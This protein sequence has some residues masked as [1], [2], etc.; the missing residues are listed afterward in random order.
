MFEGKE[1]DKKEINNTYVCEKVDLVE[2]YGIV[3]MI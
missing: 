3:E 2:N 1:G